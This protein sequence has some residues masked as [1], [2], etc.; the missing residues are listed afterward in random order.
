[1]HSFAL[2]SLAVIAFTGLSS[3]APVLD[4][5]GLGIP[6]RRTNT[7]TTPSEEI[8]GGPGRRLLDDVIEIRLRSEARPPSGI[9]DSANGFLHSLLGIG[10][11]RPAP[12]SA[13][14]PAAPP[15]APQSVPAPAAPPPAGPPP[16]E[17]GP[18]EAPEGSLDTRFED[19]PD[20]GGLVAGPNAGSKGGLLGVTLVPGFI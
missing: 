1:M 14:A 7:L 20:L 9:L 6:E 8:L 10:P 18:S 15:P 16:S 4:P 19:A 13:P 2:L 3:A 17:V 12:Q 5:S 11:P